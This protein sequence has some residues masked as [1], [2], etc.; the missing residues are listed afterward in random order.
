MTEQ[1]LVLIKPDGVQRLLVG[2]ILARYE[3]RGLRLAALKLMT[4][5]REL[6]ERHYAVHSAKPFFRGLVEF[7]TSG[8]LV[9]AVLEGPNAIAVV[10]AMNGAT[11]P[12]E[13]APGTIR[14]DFALET[15]QNLVHASDSAETAAAEIELW[16]GAAELLDYGRDIDRW[17]LAPED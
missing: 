16:F 6:A 14:G 12:H 7:I 3:E 5:D 9:A 11:R 15:A 8:P 13:A 1:T 4:V 17:V 10:R 2:R